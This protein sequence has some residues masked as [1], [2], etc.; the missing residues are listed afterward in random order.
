MIERNTIFSPCRMYRYTLW[1]EW[2]KPK[3]TFTEM[4][5]PNHFFSPPRGTHDQFVQFIG[6]NPS[7]ADEKLDDPTIRRCIQFA[8]DW[9][10]GAFCMTNIFAWR[11]TLPEKMKQAADPIGSDND[12]WLLEISKGAGL[13]VA[14][15]GNHGTHLYR[16]AKVKMMLRDNGINLMCFRM[17]KA[18][19]PEHPLYM[20][21]DTKP[22]PFI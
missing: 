1:R 15:W 7:T 6:L 2:P 11:D 14:A 21:G 20:K 12:R 19:Q 9:G 18:K 13:V 3:V 22:I 16:G 10:Y 8:K 17:T 4:A 5:D